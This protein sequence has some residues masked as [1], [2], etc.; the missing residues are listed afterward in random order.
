E[1]SQRRELRDMAEYVR[2]RATTFSKSVVYLP[3]Q[4]T[5]A[6]AVGPD[7]LL[8]V[9][10]DSTRPG[11]KPASGVRI[12]LTPPSAADS[13]LQPAPLLP[14]DTLAHRWGVVVARTGDGRTLSLAGLTGGVIHTFCGE[15]GFPELVFDAPVP[16]A[17]RGGG[18]FDLDGNAIAQAVPCNGRIALV[19]LRDLVWA[20]AL[21]AS[22]EPR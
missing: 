15:L 4:Q 19:P 12:L 9:I 17:F 22:T 3:D 16:A 11:G 1:R 7:S 18:L 10:P 5:S 14:A 2:D 13:A 21:Q 6:L 20:L 8:T